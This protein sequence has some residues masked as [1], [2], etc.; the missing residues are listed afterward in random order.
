[1]CKI[2]TYYSVIRNNSQRKGKE[3][4]TNASDGEKVEIIRC[5]GDL[6]W[7]TIAWIPSIKTVIGSDVL[8]NQAHPFT[9]EVTKDQR[10]LWMKDIEAIRNLGAEVIIPG[11]M[12]ED[13]SL[14][15]SSLTFMEQ[16]LIATEEELE[17]NQDA[18]N[19][20]PP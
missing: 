12:R 2:C 15:E 13:L 20:R 4:W 7:N 16:Y 17:R 9:C 1:M 14:D 18:A 8:F 19:S 10:K 3:L 6:M 5:M 11:H